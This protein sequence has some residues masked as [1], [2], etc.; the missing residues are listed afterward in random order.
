MTSDQLIEVDICIYEI[1]MWRTLLY[2]VDLMVEIMNRM[3]RPSESVTKYITDMQTLM[4]LHGDLS[5]QEQLTWLFRNLLPEY[6]LHLFQCNFDDISSFVKATREL[7]FLMQEVKVA[8][9]QEHTEEQTYSSASRTDFSRH[10][11]SKRS[12][13]PVET[14]CNPSIE[15]NNHTPPPVKIPKVQQ[16]STNQTNKSNL[17]PTSRN[18]FTPSTS[19]TEASKT[20]CWRCGK[21]GH[22]RYECKGPKK[23]FCSRCLKT[24]IM[25]KDCPC[26]QQ[27]SNT[28]HD[29]RAA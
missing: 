17:F 28:K 25:S 29:K 6:R 13:S 24:N 4:R 14:V 3:Q 21:Q 12:S 11:S 5:V 26:N 27:I 10:S 19:R 2:Q 7:E 15:Q 9:E 1:I 18:H 20:L 23:L 8:Q 22:F 16:S